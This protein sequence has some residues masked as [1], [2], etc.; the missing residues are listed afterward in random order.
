MDIAYLHLYV[1]NADSWR[2]WFVQ[3]LNFQSMSTTGLAQFGDRA[4]QSGHIRILLSSEHSGNPEV[5]QF[6]Q[7]H[8]EGVADVAFRVNALDTWITQVQQQRDALIEGIQTWESP[9]GPWRWCRVRGWGGIYHTLIEQPAVFTPESALY[10]LKHSEASPSPR[11][12][13]ID[14]AV[15]NVPK[16]ELDAAAAWYETCLGF[17]RQQ[18]FAIA[19]QQSGL[20]SLVLKHPQGSAMMPVNEPTSANSQIQEFLDLHGGAGIQHAALRTHNLVRTVSFLRQRG[21]AFLTVPSTYYEQLKQRPGF[22]HQADDWD[23]IAQQQIL[24]D[25]PSE[26]PHLRLLQTFTQPLLEQPTFFWELIER[27]TKVTMQGLKQVEGFGEGNFQ[28]LFEAIEREQ[29]QR[30]SL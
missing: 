16:G 8:P 28:A 17:T 19:T 25:W 26:E 1:R 7:Q 22:W 24:V 3:N 29:Q 5:T 15:L 23:A 9:D 14:H 20:R 12:Q 4:V 13:S 11:W 27:Q 18:Q 6:L 2:D 30:G 21:L 10:E